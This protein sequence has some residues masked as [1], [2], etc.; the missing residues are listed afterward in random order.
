MTKTDTTTGTQVI[1]KGFRFLHKTWKSPAFSFAQYRELPV[2]DTAQEFV[3]TRI[4]RGTCYFRP[5]YRINGEIRN[6][7]TPF[8]RDLVKMDEIILEVL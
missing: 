4:A 7:G 8:Y 3:V 1:T 2:R 5:V 6:Y